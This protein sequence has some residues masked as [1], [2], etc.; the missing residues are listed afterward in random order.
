MEVEFVVVKTRA[1][2]PAKVQ[3]I[4]NAKTERGECLVRSC[5]SPRKWL[6]LC[7][8]CH[9]K[10]LRAES[11]LPEGKRPLFRARLIVEGLLLESRQGRTSK[12]PDAFAEFCDAFID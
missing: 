4:V 11:K 2:P 9:R 7:Q 1:K 8:A 3:A 6:G 5:T 12:T 10:F